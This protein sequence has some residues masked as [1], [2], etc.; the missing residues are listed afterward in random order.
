MSADMNMTFD[1]YNKK[2]L[3]KTQSMYDLDYKLNKTFQ[4]QGY[5]FKWY[6][7]DNDDVC[8]QF[9]ELS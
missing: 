9:V 4:H 1:E 3:G 7:C 5:T 6:V 2:A 8:A